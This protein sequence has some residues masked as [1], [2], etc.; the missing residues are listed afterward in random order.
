V[1]T[2]HQEIKRHRRHV[3]SDAEHFGLA[4]IA[5]QLAS[6]NAD[7]GTELVAVEPPRETGRRVNQKAGRGL[8]G[9]PSRLAPGAPNP[10]DSTLQ[11]ER[12]AQV[13][14]DHGARARENEPVRV[15][16]RRPALFGCVDIRLADEAALQGESET[17]AHAVANGDIDTHESAAERAGNGVRGRQRHRV[18]PEPYPRPT[19]RARPRWPRHGAKVLCRV[20]CFKAPCDTRGQNLPS[21]LR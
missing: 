3:R 7:R 12:A 4:V 9:Q 18:L 8:V 13:S 1:I 15:G 6:I 10:V 5:V 14:I 2:F 20:S 16:H 19:P 17:F 21:L 11:M